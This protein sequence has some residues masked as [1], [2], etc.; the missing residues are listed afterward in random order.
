MNISRMV[1]SATMAALLAGTA[2]VSI[3]APLASAPIKFTSNVSVEVEVADEHGKKHV[4]RRPA[5]KAIP[6]TVMLYTNT[7]ENIG[8]KPVEGI[9]TTNP[10]PANTEYQAG[11][12]YGDN[13]EITFSVDGG[14][15]FAAPEKL[16]VKVADGSERTAKP[17]E[18]TH[19]RWVYKTALAAGEIGE[20]GFR[21][22]IK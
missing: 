1:V 18:F 16:K 14:K 19:I 8:K 20:A 21:V 11:S 13:T 22:V 5:D 12:A 7:F 2:T 4:E 3:A 17:S 15:N 10:V 9:A 6:G